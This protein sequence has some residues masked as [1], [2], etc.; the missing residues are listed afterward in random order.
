MAACSLA[1]L[2]LSRPRVLAQTPPLVSASTTLNCGA[3]NGQPQVDTERHA[4]VVKGSVPGKVGNVVEIT[5][6][7][8]VGVNW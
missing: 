3:P 2:F 8:L 7:K 6:A 4:L 1:P 5:P